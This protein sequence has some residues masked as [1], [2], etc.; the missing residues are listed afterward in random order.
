M[1]PALDELEKIFTLDENEKEEA[2]AS[3]N[4]ILKEKTVDMFIESSMANEE[5]EYA[6]DDEEA[7][8]N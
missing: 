6:E 1:I 7:G 2:M 8:L 4:A 3:L 5:T